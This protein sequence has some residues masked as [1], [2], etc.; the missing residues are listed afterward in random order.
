M[1]LRW[2]ADGPEVDL[3]LG[4]AARGPVAH[5]FRAAAAAARVALGANVAHPRVVA[6]LADERRAGRVEAAEMVGACAARAR[7]QRARLV[8]GRL[9]VAADGLRPDES[10]VNQL[11]TTANRL[12][13]DY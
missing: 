6:R 4:G 11:R 2:G 8:R 5:R 10:T 3:Q 7:V 9:A 13:I 1:V 12:L